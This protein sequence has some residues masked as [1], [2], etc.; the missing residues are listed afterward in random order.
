MFVEY[1]SAT[2]A[3]LRYINTLSTKKYVGMAM[4]K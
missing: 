4:K 3:T 2:V 1:T